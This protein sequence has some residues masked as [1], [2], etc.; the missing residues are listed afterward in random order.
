MESI[1]LE[2]ELKSEGIPVLRINTDYTS[3]DIEQI[4]NRIEAFLELIKK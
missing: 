3:E 1:G 4:N 2:K